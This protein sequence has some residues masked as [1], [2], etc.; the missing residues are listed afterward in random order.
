MD[1]IAAR[2]DKAAAPPVPLWRSEAKAIAA[3]RLQRLLHTL[4]EAMLEGNEC[5]AVR[6]RPGIF[7][8]PFP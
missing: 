7:R 5:N 1:T 2:T 4:L 6:C 3:G 8:Y